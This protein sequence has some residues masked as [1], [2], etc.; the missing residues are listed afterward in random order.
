MSERE[1][2][3]MRASGAS[4]RRLAEGIHYYPRLQYQVIVLFE[5]K[6]DNDQ[7]K[8][9]KAPAMQATVLCHRVQA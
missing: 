8:T 9:D 7:Y 5:K 1:D 4:T 2:L 6:K 3:Y